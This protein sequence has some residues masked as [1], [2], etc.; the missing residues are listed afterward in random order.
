MSR[1]PFDFGDDDRTVLQPTPGRRTAAPSAPAGGASV[2][3]E[4]A[5]SAADQLHATPLLGGINKLEKAASRLIPLLITIKNSQQH[6]HPEQ[7]RN[8]LINELN[9][10]K[11]RAQPILNDPKKVTQASYVMCTAL[12][13]A[14]LNTPWGHESNWSQHNLLSTFHDDVSGGERFFSLLKGLGKDPEENIDLLELMYVCLALGYEGAYR[15]A[16]KGQETLVKVR[17]WLYDIIQSVRTNPEKVLS[18]N[19]VGSGV[20]ESRL[21]KLTPIWVITA[22]VLAIASFAYIGLRYNIASFSDDVIAGYFNKDVKPLSIRT[23]VPPIKP[24]PIAVATQEE[25]TI[26]LTQLLQ[27]EIEQDSIQVDESFDSGSVR[28]KGANLFSSGGVS[29]NSDFAPLIER[30]SKAI[31]QFDGTVIVSGHSDNIPIRSG[32]FSSNLELSQARA[33]SVMAF[34]NRYQ[35]DPT[36]VSSVGKGSLEPIAD[37]GTA[38]GRNL[39]RRVEISIFY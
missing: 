30:I 29:L 21:P 34:F 20:K 36:R 37:N 7:L 14:A 27:S 38:A 5:P 22:A 32:R 15:I 4:S 33:D 17:H 23:V 1:D 12:D 18:A 6:P 39:N 28:I 8:K 24:K 35:D 25:S 26:T 3:Q 10:F 9:E 19:W 31:A 2:R 11:Q 16:P 13:E